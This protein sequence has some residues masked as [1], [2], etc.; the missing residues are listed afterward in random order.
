MLKL[1]AAA[2]ASGSRLEDA[3]WDERLREAVLPLL[4]A[5]GQTA[6]ESALDRLWSTDPRGYDALADAL[7]SSVECAEIEYEGRAHDALM[8]VAPLLAWSRGGVASGPLRAADVEAL[9]V[10][11]GA[12]VFAAD[13]RVSLV[14][15]LFTPEQLPAA[16]HDEHDLAKALFKAAAGSG[17]HTVRP[18]RVPEPLDFVSDSRYLLGAVLVPKGAPLFAWQEDQAR[19][20][21]ARDAW[22]A[23]AREVLASFLTGARFELLTPGAFYSTLRRVDQVSREYHLT[24]GVEYLVAALGVPASE[25]SASIAPFHEDDLVEYRIG[26]TQGRNDA[27]FHGVTWPVLADSDVEAAPARIREL[28]V[29]AG[30]AQIHEHEHRFPVEFCDDCG[31]PLFPNRQGETVHAELPEDRTVGTVSLH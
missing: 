11:L 1:A 30:V 3:W 26:L 28:L 19:L 20:D 25:L 2:A 4:T 21:S 10:Q 31:A 27:I 9:R 6:I 12:H 29:K 13:A 18:D 7:E 16:Y 22:D 23:Q 5:A 8:F 14:N 15:R 17:V 24:A